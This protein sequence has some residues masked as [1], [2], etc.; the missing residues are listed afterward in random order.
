[1]PDC[2]STYARVLCRALHCCPVPCATLLPK[3]E[4]NSQDRS[5]SVQWRLPLPGGIDALKDND[6]LASLVFNLCG[7]SWSVLARRLSRHHQHL[8]FVSSKMC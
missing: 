4:M 7:Y 1:M 3:D 8:C 2:V 6:C 5:E